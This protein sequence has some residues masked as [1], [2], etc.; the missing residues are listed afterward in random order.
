MAFSRY[1]VRLR[2]D[3]SVFSTLLLRRFDPSACRRERPCERE[4]DLRRRGVIAVALLQ[5]FFDPLDPFANFSS[6]TPRF[7]LESLICHFL[8]LRRFFGS[9]YS[10][11]EFVTIIPLELLYV[12]YSST[13]RRATHTELFS[14]LLLRFPV[15][16]KLSGGFLV[17]F[18][19]SVRDRLP[20]SPVILSPVSLNHCLSILAPF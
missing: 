19:V 9:E 11:D 16:R 12:V 3:L 20:V 1:S 5:T 4:R 7:D 2:S 14:D 8:A 13:D 18:Q 17:A 15:S 6:V 10:F